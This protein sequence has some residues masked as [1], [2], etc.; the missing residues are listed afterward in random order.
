[1]KAWDYARTIFQSEK[2]RIVYIKAEK[3]TRKHIFWYFEGLNVVPQG[4]FGQTKSYFEPEKRPAGTFWADKIG[5]WARES[6]RRGLSGKIFDK[7][8]IQGRMQI[9]EKN[10][11]EGFKSRFDRLER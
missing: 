1:M 10:V 8:R 4:P 7:L 9:F 11:P 2:L 6:S 5:F 3:D